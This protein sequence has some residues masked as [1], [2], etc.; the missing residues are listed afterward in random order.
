MRADG[1][2][3]TLHLPLTRRAHNLLCFVGVDRRQG[4][5]SVRRRLWVHPVPT[6]LRALT[7]LPRLDSNQASGIQ[8][9]VSYQIDDK[10]KGRRVRGPPTVS[11]GRATPTRVLSP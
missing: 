1:E 4:H 9:A 2:T 3:R 7:W 6:R 10:G 8:S 11:A 5:L